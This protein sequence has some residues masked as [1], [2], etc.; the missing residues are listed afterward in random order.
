MSGYTMGGYQIGLRG[1]FADGSVLVE[2][3]LWNRAA[4]AWRPTGTYQ[5]VHRHKVHKA[6]AGW[7]DIMRAVDALPLLTFATDGDTGRDTDRDTDIDTGIAPPRAPIAP[8]Q[9]GGR[10]HAHFALKED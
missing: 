6:G 3:F 7:G 4:R 5:T 1:R 9:P 8:R 2:T 10:L